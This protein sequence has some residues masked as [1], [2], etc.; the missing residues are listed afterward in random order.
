VIGDTPPRGYFAGTSL[1]AQK[2]SR[3]CA[4]VD[5]LGGIGKRSD[6]H[7]DAGITRFS[8]TT[9]ARVNVRRA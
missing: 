4:M 1:S 3:A 5:P 7:R 2:R 9:P 6:A 8:T